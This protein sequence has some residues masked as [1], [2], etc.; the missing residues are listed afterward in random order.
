[1]TKKIYLETLKC[2]LG[3][4]HFTLLT[5]K[6][7]MQFSLKEIPFLDKLVNRSNNN[8]TQIKIYRHPTD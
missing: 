6:L 7:E 2:A 5:I 8:T 4:L 1:M 3:L